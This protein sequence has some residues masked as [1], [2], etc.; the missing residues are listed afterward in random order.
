VSSSLALNAGTPISHSSRPR[1]AIVGGGIVGLAHAW[2][3]A[4]RG[5]QVL[6]FE[7]GQ[8]AG[9][10]S[11]RNFG[12]IWP[13]GQPAGPNL[14]TAMHSRSLWRRLILETG[15]WAAECGSLHL[16]YQADEWEV[17]SE[18]ARHANG[19]EDRGAEHRCELLSP[20]E[21]CERSRAARSEGLLG[22]L[23]SPAEM[24]VD[25]RQIIARMPE[26]LKARFGVQLHY[27]VTI[28][29]VAA[30]SVAASNGDLWQVD[31]VIVAAGSELSTLYPD[32]Y[33]AAGFRRCKL[34]MMRTAPKREW[35]L[36]P[37][38]ASGLTLRHYEAFAGCTSLTA[39]KERIA[40]K[41]PEL[42]RY[43]IHVMA[44]QNGVGEVILG[45]SHEYDDDVTPFDKA[46]ID[47]LIIREL[48]RII[49]LP[50]WTITE[51]WHGIY[52]KISGTLHYVAEPEPAVHISIASGGC[53]MT[54]SFGVCEE[55]WSE[56]D[57][58]PTA[59]VDEYPEHANISRT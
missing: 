25:P 8:R 23:W 14:R 15:L 54:M 31:R 57:G 46:C 26:W 52:L 53:G 33:A 9:G 28:D 40:R 4:R 1:V 35:S 56:W 17:L 12:M 2:A 10:A 19:T 18:F 20:A 43:G 51:H 5:W 7:R 49:D 58:N 41:T 47:D 27:G 13:I 11:I 36:G 50:D 39:L 42:D 16:A 29:R 32:L 45:D 37:M 24:C 59:K 34:Q 22:G 44:A 21:V 3:A 38:I 48:R 30:R 6:L 55:Q